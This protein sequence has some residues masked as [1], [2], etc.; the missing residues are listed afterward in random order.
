MDK[1][2]SKREFQLNEMEESINKAYTNSRIY[3]ERTKV[4]HD[5]QVLRK[6]FHPSQKALLYNL[7]LHLILGKLK[8]HWMRPYIVLKVFTCGVVEVEN[9]KNGDE[10]LKINGPC[11]KPFS[12]SLIRRGRRCL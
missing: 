8:S 5:K 11:L 12:E 2:N 4:F 10:I 7:R 9:P 6:Q 3:K 1:A